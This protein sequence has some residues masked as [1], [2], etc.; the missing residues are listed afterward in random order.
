[1][2]RDILFD[3]YKNISNDIITEELMKNKLLYLNTFFKIYIHFTP[4]LI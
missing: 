2:I 3:K 1:M 4:F